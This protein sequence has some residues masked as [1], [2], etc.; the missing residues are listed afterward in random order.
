M[1]CFCSM[2]V[3]KTGTWWGWIGWFLFL[4]MLFFP[5]LVMEDRELLLE[6]FSAFSIGL[7]LWWIVDV[8]DQEVEGWKIL[9]GSAMFVIGWF[10]KGYMMLIATWVIYWMK[11]RE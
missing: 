8:A 1:R 4:G 9:T 3:E 7:V 11:V 5:Y 6:V 2:V 10:P